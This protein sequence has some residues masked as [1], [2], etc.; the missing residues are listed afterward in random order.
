MAIERPNWGFVKRDAVE[1]LAAKYSADELAPAFDITQI[2][3]VVRG[4]PNGQPFMVVANAHYTVPVLA[5]QAKDMLALA[6]EHGDIS[7]TQAAHVD[8]LT[9]GKDDEEGAVAIMV[10]EHDPLRR[11]SR[12]ILGAL[13]RR[14]QA[15]KKAL[16][17]RPTTVELPASSIGGKYSSMLAESRLAENGTLAEITTPRIGD[18]FWK[19][20]ECGEQMYVLRDT[21]ESSPFCSPCSITRS[22]QGLSVEWDALV[23]A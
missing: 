14:E 2:V 5:R 4:G 6:V 18:P 3:A 13:K 16:K 1:N 8:V 19:C 17:A 11:P 15:G 9:T 21:G 10:A 7:T 23:T 20:S 22:E 12:A